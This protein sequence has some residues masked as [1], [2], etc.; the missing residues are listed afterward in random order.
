L[1]PHDH[2]DP[3][4]NPATATRP[5]DPEA[6]VFDAPWQ[7]QALALAEALKARG[8]FTAADWATALGAERARQAAARGADTNQSYFEAVVT[9]LERLSAAEVPPDAR[10]SRKAAWEAAYAR[11]PHGM[12]VLLAPGD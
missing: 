12:P 1:A 10:A 8:L 11:T 7:V 9:T 6:P 4:E 3:E 2:G 5:F